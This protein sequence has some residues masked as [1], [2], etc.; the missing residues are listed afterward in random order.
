LTTYSEA[1]TMWTPKRVV[2]LASGFVV[3]CAAYAGYAQVLGGIDGLPALPDAYLPPSPTDPERPPERYRVAPVDDRL[4]QAFGPSCSELKMPIKVE[5][6]RGVVIAAR[7]CVFQPGGR[8]VQ[9]TPISV[10]FFKPVVSKDGTVQFPEIN[11]IQAATATLTL[12]API[13]GPLDMARRRIVAARLRGV[14]AINPKEVAVPIVIRNNRR[15]YVRTDDIDIQIPVGPVL[16]DDEKRLIHTDDFVRML[17]L[18]SQPPT[19][20]TAKGM[21]VYLAPTAPSDGKGKAS[22]ARPEG[23]GG[24]VERVRLLGNVDMHLYNEP[25][26][27]FPGVGGR[28]AK[29]EAKPG[30][31]KSPPA[32]KDHIWITSAG[33]FVYDLPH[34]HA[35]FDIPEETSGLTPEV[36]TVRRNPPLEPGA[37]DKSD[38]LE[39]EHLELQF[40]R[41]SD[42]PPAKGG[43]PAAEGDGQGPNLDI[44]WVHAWGNKIKILSAE[45]HIESS[46]GNDLFYQALTHTS[47]LKGTPRVTLHKE[48]DTIEAPVLELIDQKDQKDRGMQQVT[49]TGTGSIHM[50]ARKAGQSPMHARWK[51]KFVSVREG[52]LDVLT[53]K[54]DAA[55]VED[56]HLQPEDIFADDKLLA[57][58][59]VLKADDLQIWLDPP[60]PIA[61]KPAGATPPGAS[62]AA[63]PAPAAAGAAPRP[64]AV[65]EASAG[66][67]RPRRVEAN[68]HVVARSPEMRILE[69]PDQATQR[70]TIH[71]K[72]TAAPPPAVPASAKPGDT[73]R[74]PAPV[75]VKPTDPLPPLPLGPDPVVVPGDPAKPQPAKPEPAKPEPAKPSR[76]VELCAN[77]ITAYV[78]RYDGGKTEL[79]KLE[80]EGAVWVQQQPSGDDKGFTIR[81]DKLVLT[82]KAAGNHLKVIG[83]MAELHSDRLSI[84]G[85]EVEIDQGD[86]TATVDGPGFMQMENT[87]DFEGKPLKTPEVLEVHWNKLMRFEGSFAEFHGSIQA[88]QGNS[89]LK[90]QMLQVYFDKPVSLSDQRNAPKKEHA[91]GEE[92]ARAKKLICDRSVKVEEEVY[93]VWF[94]L[95]DKSLTSLREARVPDPVLERLGQLKDKEFDSRE[96]FSEAL[97][98]VLGRD[99]L[100]RFEGLVANHAEYEPQPRRLAGFKSLDCLDLT[101][102]NLEH[103]MS[104]HGPGILRIVQPGNGIGAPAEGAGARPAPRPAEAKPSKPAEPPPWALTLV[105]YG[106]FG[107]GL[108]KSGGRMDA[109]NERHTAVFYDDIQVLHLP[110]TSDPKRLREPINVPAMLDHLPPGGLYME[111]RKK[112]SV[113]S[114]EEAAG[115]APAKDAGTGKHVMT[116]SGQVYLKA[117]DA[118]GKVFWGTAEEVH[119]Y[120]AKEQVIFD[121]K[122]GLAEVY[123]VERRGETPKPFR[124]KKIIYWRN[125]GR[126]VVEQAVEASGGTR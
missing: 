34:S 52:E 87:T 121:G 54:G 65:A 7:D 8:D 28:P 25:G 13:S 64:G 67:R 101:V 86:N 49:A 58:K 115:P 123:Q 56:E 124:G 31:P 62:K 104:A 15:T 80:T 47:V 102:W 105:T 122:D 83:D 14:P 61:S 70:L 72:D 63:K 88:T 81:G 32:A 90:C 113:Y 22:K 51:D 74:A 4:Q 17:D 44:E 24:T 27:G 11:T 41:K 97:A 30:A 71:F 29:S 95:T 119:Y 37:D 110:W 91:K 1:L 26:A 46:D 57:C 114:P 2:L 48:Q 55:L 39:C 45:Q 43:G 60:P 59:S 21:D 103:I 23:N 78:L 12:D 94:K 93:E 3:F 107:D 106:R 96:R 125:D 98:T 10:A 77:F 16:F 53:F 66:G 85:P 36:V 75:T 118:N 5:S 18:Q 42:E 40:R 82:R 68:G 126:V 111:C 73:P 76:P 9:L 35:R 38:T 79:D 84:C 117:T 108:G 120:E 99:V 20:V 69:R 116:G 112:L 109:A 50:A 19:E 92:P 6:P 33:P 89:R 100:E